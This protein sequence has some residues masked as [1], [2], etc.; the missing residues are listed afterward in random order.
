M[1]VLVHGEDIQ[2]TGLIHCKPILNR[3]STRQIILILAKNIEIL[4][5]IYL[6][7]FT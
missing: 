5:D 2:N 6:G 1:K 3:A 7:H 4:H